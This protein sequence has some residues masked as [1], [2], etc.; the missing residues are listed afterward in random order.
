MLAF[1]PAPDQGGQVGYGLGIEQRMFPGGIEL[2]GHLGTAA[3][4]TA[5]VA[6]LRRQHVTIVSTP[7]LGR[8]P[9]PPACPGSEGAR[10]GSS[11]RPA[12][13]ANRQPLPSA[14]P[15]T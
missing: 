10:G 14:S 4:Y 9:I 6:R 2:I 12:N 15:P 11:V 8:R 7:K 1:A 3:G 13:G 5:Y